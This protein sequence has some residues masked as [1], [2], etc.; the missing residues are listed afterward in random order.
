MMI[1]TNVMKKQYQQQRGISRSPTTCTEM[2]AID[3][4][5]DSATK[6]I[7]WVRLD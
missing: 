1:A 7:L 2:D 6:Y 3:A 4:Q 5:N